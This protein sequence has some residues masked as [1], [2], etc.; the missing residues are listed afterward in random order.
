MNGVFL[1]DVC[2]CMLVWFWVKANET[3]CKS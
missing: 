3:A 1:K 2:V